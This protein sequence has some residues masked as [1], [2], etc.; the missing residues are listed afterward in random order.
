VENGHESGGV[1]LVFAEYCGGPSRRIL[2]NGGLTLQLGKW[3]GV[4]KPEK[5]ACSKK[6]G[7]TKFWMKWKKTWG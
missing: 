3:G 4:S 1:G 6:N 5:R 7:T 2:P